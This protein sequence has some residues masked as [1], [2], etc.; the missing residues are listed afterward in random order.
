MLTLTCICLYAIDECSSVNQTTDS[1]P[2]R[3]PA[4]INLGRPL[5]P[6]MHWQQEHNYKLQREWH[7]YSTVAG[8]PP[9]TIRLTF[10]S[11]ATPEAMLILTLSPLKIICLVST[12]RSPPTSIEQHADYPVLESTPDIGSTE[13]KQVAGSLAFIARQGKIQQAYLVQG[14][15][16]TVIRCACIQAA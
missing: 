13:G 9:K 12:C 11:V 16:I 8:L 7:I 15:E 2:A 14:Q 4:G 10:T 6:S 3:Q 1:Q 5:S